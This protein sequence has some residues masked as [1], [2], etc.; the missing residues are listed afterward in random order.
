MK[1]LYLWSNITPPKIVRNFSFK[2]FLFRQMV[3]SIRGVERFLTNRLV[4][5]YFEHCALFIQAN[6]EDNS[7]IFHEGDRYQNNILF[8]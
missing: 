3:R 8:M 6:T 4:G 7:E 5:H 2:S 1:S